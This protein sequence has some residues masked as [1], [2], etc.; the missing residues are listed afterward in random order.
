MAIKSPNH[1]SHSS[2][3]NYTFFEG[4]ACGIS[5]LIGFIYYPGCRGAR[6]HGTGLQ[7]EPDEPAG[8]EEMVLMNL[9]GWHLDWLTD[10]VE[11][12]DEWD[13]IADQCKNYMES[14][15]PDYDDYEPWDGPY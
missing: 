13:D 11:A 3:K 6:E 12:A 5:C 10:K 15:E 4:T 14:Q 1:M 8:I 7:L 9:K 2:W